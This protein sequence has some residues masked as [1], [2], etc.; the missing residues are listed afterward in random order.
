[1]SRLPF[2][3]FLGLAACS[4]RQPTPA[5]ASPSGPTAAKPPAPRQTGQGYV[6][7]VTAPPAGVGAE[8]A[9]RLTLK[10]VDGYH[11]NK[12]FPYSLKVSP[13]TGVEVVK[14]Q[15]SVEDAI[16]LEDLEAAWD[17][18]FTSQAAGDKKFAATFRF[19][20][21]TETSC[22]PKVEQLAWDVAVK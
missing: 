3:L 6:V 4:Q 8:V 7:E 1:M 17:V 14:A 5:T 10:A 18:K 22:D 21:C 12:D 11:V 16:K 19:A 13:P 20:V 9:A 2:V 15:Q